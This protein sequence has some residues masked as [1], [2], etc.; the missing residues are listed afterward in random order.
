VIPC[1]V[2]LAAP[3]KCQNFCSF[4]LTFVALSSP[5][6]V[7]HQPRHKR[8][9][10][11]FFPSLR[12][13]SQTKW[14]LFALRSTR[15]GIPI[16]AFSTQ[17]LPCHNRKSPKHFRRLSFSPEL[18]PILKGLVS[19]PFPHIAALIRGLFRIIVFQLADRH[20]PWIFAID[21]RRFPPP[22]TAP[23]EPG[24][25]PPSHYSKAA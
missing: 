19:L 20:G 14:R 6:S 18:S 12:P 5:I 17:F 9:L 11:R 21:R 2:S 8:G 22:Q 3:N 1:A 15:R 24:G 16:V 7:D 4:F 10:P 25:D 13:P 23:N